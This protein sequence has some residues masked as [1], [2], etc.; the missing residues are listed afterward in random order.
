MAIIYLCRRSLRSLRG[1]GNP[2]NL[3]AIACRRCRPSARA[4]GLLGPASADGVQQ[5]AAGSLMFLGDKP[6]NAAAIADAGAI[7]PMVLWLAPGSQ[8]QV[9]SD[10]A[11]ALWQLARHADYASTIAGAGATRTRRGRCGRL[12]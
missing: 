4:A 10:A 9:Q 7:P 6:E 1:D 8:G 3:A 12:R 5:L 11:G 2:E